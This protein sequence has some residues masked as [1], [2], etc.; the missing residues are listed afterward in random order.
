MR[1][2]LLIIML[3]VCNIQ[4]YGQSQIN[5]V[6]NPLNELVSIYE[7]GENIT[8]CETN[9]RNLLNNWNTKNIT[10]ANEYE[11]VDISFVE[12]ISDSIRYNYYRNYFSGGEPVYS[13]IQSSRG[14][15]FNGTKIYK[16]YVTPG[17]IH[18]EFYDR[19]LLPE[20]AQEIF[21][22]EFM[23]QVQ[24]LLELEINIDTLSLMYC[25]GEIIRID[26]IKSGSDFIGNFIQKSHGGYNLAS[27]DS[28]SKNYIDISIMREKS[29]D[30]L[31][32]QKRR[33]LI[34]EDLLIERI[35][36]QVSFN[37]QVH[38][39]DKVY[40]IKFKYL[41][42]TYTDYVICNPCSKKVVMDC[43]FKNII[44]DVKK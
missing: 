12:S 21:S 43:F 37:K 6:S 44:I 34:L 15:G 41:G 31:N 26:T 29:S 5:K 28:I 25:S 42:I 22:K 11:F 30:D 3:L 19:R 39:K 40:S 4:I 36:N 10:N 9:F 24:K 13:S 35:S 20:K 27:T 14:T 33:A 16:Y 32:M 18:Q 1:R 17:Y 2:K 38:I 23:Q 7:Y 8:S